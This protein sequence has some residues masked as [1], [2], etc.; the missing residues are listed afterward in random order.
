[1]DSDYCTLMSNNTNTHYIDTCIV[2]FQHKGSNLVKKG[3]LQQ[4]WSED[5]IGLHLLSNSSQ[6]WVV[7]QQF[8]MLWNGYNL[9]GPAVKW[10]HISMV[11]TNILRKTNKLIKD[12]KGQKPTK[13]EWKCV[14]THWHLENH[15][16]C[17]N[18]GKR[19]S[20]LRESILFCI[21]S[22]T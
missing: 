19:Q 18:Q 22:I 9:S 6:W 4:H 13:T 8:V 15:L 12:M 20:I 7:S 16:F 1:M 5:H 17:W 14:C 3:T 10:G 21:V 11:S 2:S